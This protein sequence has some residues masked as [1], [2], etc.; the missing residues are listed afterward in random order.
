MSVLE[1]NAADKKPSSDNP[2]CQIESPKPM[3]TAVSLGLQSDRTSTK[4]SKHQATLSVA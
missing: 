4:A 3:D 2:M 1:N